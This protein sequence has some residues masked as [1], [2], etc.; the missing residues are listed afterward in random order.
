MKIHG[1]DSFTPCNIFTLRN[2]RPT[3]G[4]QKRTLLFLLFSEIFQHNHNAATLR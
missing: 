2:K 4:R 3:N 1:T